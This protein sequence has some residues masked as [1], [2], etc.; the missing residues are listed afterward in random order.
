M[1]RIA[2]YLFYDENGVVDDYIPY[3]LNKLNKHVQKIIVICNTPL[4]KNSQLKLEN[5]GVDLLFRE[6]MGFDVWG[7]KDGLESIGFNKLTKNYDELIL[8]NYTFFGPIFSLES[9]SMTWNLDSV[10]FGELANMLK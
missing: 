7:Y 5:L 1:H 4:T 2:F 9:Y 10:T 3:K 8:L 6:N